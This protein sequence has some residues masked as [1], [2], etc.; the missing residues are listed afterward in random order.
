[1]KLYMQKI[2]TQ[3]HYILNPLTPYFCRRM[4]Y[5]QHYRCAVWVKKQQHQ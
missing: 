1:M 4:E 3:P 5:K 2:H